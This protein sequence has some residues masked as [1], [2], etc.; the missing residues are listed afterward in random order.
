[1][2][3]QKK[4]GLSCV[5]RVWRATGTFLPGALWPSPALSSGPLGPEGQEPL[6]PEGQHSPEILLM[7]SHGGRGP[8]S[9]GG[10]ALA[11]GLA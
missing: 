2:N 9:G 6:G 7:S 5:P 10:V 4:I 8:R 1:M 3:E 11:L